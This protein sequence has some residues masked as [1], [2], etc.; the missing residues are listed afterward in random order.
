[1]IVVWLLAGCAN[2]CDMWCYDTVQWHDAQAISSYLC[3]PLLCRYDIE[4]PCRILM[5][6]FLI[7]EIYLCHF[8]LIFQT[9]IL[10]VD[11][12]QLSFSNLKL[13]LNTLKLVLNTLKLDTS[14]HLWQSSSRVSVCS[15]QC[16]VQ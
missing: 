11:V 3:L 10:A 8:Q 12:V 2:T 14:L 1:M 7:G 4:L 13:V 9:L 15:E 6:R 16:A 5:C